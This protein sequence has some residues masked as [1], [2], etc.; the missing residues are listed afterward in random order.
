[1][2]LPLQYQRPNWGS[3][4]AGASG[5]TL[6]KAGVSLLLMMGVRMSLCTRSV[7]GSCSVRNIASS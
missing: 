4:E 5:S 3:A 1:M 2:G 7:V 6:R